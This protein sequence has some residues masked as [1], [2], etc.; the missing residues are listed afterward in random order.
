[1][2]VKK[3]TGRGVEKIGH[4]MWFDVTDTGD[5]IFTDPSL[6]LAELHEVKQAKRLQPFWLHIESP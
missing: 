6:L 4:A 3:K 2:F 1:M 5:V